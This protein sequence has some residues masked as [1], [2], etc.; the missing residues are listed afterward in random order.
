VVIINTLKKLQ[1]C[2][3]IILFSFCSQKTAAIPS[4]FNNC[5]V[6][7]DT[8]LE[9]LKLIESNFAISLNIR[10]VREITDRD[11]CIDRVL[12]TNLAQGADL[13]DGSLIDLVVGIKKDEVTDFVK[14]TEL[15]LYL[16]QLEEKNL[17]DLNLIS[18]SNFGSGKLE[19]I[20]DGL[21]VIT[22]IEKNNKLG[23]SFIFSEASGKISGLD[24]SGEVIEL[25]DISNK[26]IREREAGLHTFIFKTIEEKDFLLVTYSGIDSSYYLSAF[27]IESGVVKKDE[28]VIS[29][30]NFSAD[31]N[32]HFGGKIFFD[33][34]NL[35]FC[36]GDQNS[37]GNSAKLDTPWG[38]VIKIQNQNLLT[39]AIDLMNDDRVS[40]IAYGLR[41]PWSCFP[42]GN[43]LILLD[44]G[45][46][47]WEEVNI[48]ENFDSVVEPMFF[49][50]PW[51]ES[52]FDANYKNTPVSN[53]L[54]LQ[55]IDNTKYP[56]YL[57]PHAND[58]CAIIGGTTID[59]SNKWKDY[60]F[61]GDFCTGNIW[62]INYQKDIKLTV[63]ERDIIP[64]S[65]TTISDSNNETLLVGTT[66]GQILEI[67]LP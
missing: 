11:E 43:D 27:E 61:V 9:E 28:I 1:V 39:K 13:K 65:I 19:V 25:L 32:V 17:L 21:G 51:L 46:S 66:S 5:Q 63:L 4:E 8:A 30:F 29:K 16:N 23:F 31:T 47:H 20:K 59:K 37:P 67:F 12:G 41:N 22:H 36:T 60:F 57:Y 44:V 10:I 53:E 49:G 58:Y 6:S 26:T 2:V 48:I 7:L 45:N 14:E 18:A 24:K 56:I 50:W 35:Y 42:Q 64:Y 62:A 15:D 38:K 34:N 52:F 33:R 3:F 54:K 55:Q 40:F